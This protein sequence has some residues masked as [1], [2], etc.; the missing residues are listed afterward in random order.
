MG[1]GGGGFAGG[2]FTRING[3]VRAVTGCVVGGGGFAGHAVAGCVSGG[4]G[5]AGSPE[6]GDCTLRAVAG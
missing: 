3:T 2:C 4:G 6:T 5:F 1:G